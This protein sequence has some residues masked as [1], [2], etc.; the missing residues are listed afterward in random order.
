MDG[1]VVCL[2]VVSIIFFAFF[3][4]ASASHYKSKFNVKYTPRNMFPYELNYEAKVTDNW[5][6]NILYLFFSMAMVGVFV[7]LFGT[8]ESSLLLTLCIVGI[9]VNVLGLFLPF[10]PVKY[11]RVH[12]LIDIL[13]FILTFFTVACVALTA[14]EEYQNFN[15]VFALVMAIVAAVFAVL[16]FVILMNPK[17]TGWAKMDKNE[18]SDGTVYY[19][20]PK[21]FPLAYT[22]WLT[23]LMNIITVIL[24]A[25]LYFAI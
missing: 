21:Y 11:I 5:M 20:R 8:T 12:L 14:F 17:L 4:L 22:E 24:S 9:I 15:S 19:S 7:C 3:M 2:T 1:L 13:Y 25:I 23:I 16:Y 18:N 6:G 10:V